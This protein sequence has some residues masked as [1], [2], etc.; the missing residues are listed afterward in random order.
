MIQFIKHR[1]NKLEDLNI[2]QPE[3]GVEIDLRSDVNNPNDL[4]LSHDVFL[5]GESFT[6][7]LSNFKNCK[8]QG[9]IILNTKE[10][11]LESLTLEL[12][13]ISGVKNEIL[14]LDTTLPTLKKWTRDLKKTNFFVRW[15]SIEPIAF[16]ELQSGFCEWVWVDCFDLKPPQIDILKQL[17]R[18]FKTC[19]VSPELQGGS[20][21]DIKKFAEL[22]NFG[23]DAICTKNPQ[24]WVEEI[25]NIGQL[26]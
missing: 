10:D 21:E 20:L 4:H 11:G 22:T 26:I 13:K 7:W 17:N 8:I 25:R 18:N 6:C 15:S 19:L 2:C 24:I 3:W 16:T 5:K 12:I 23:I 9:P 14:F 1:C